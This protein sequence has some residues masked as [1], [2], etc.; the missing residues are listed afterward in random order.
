MKNRTTGHDTWAPLTLLVTVAAFAWYT[1]AGIYAACGKEDLA[2]LG[3]RIATGFESFS[4]KSYDMIDSLVNI[5]LNVTDAIYNIL[6]TDLCNIL[7]GL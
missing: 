7:L 4:C 2:S 5:I 6:Y 1:G 3:N